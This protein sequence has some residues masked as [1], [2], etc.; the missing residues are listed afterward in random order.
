MTSPTHSLDPQVPMWLRVFSWF[1]VLWAFVLIWWG[2]AVTT[3]DVGLAVPDWPFSFGKVNPEGWWNI[4]ALKLEHG[5]RLVASGLGVVVVFLF[6]FHW[7]RAEPKWR[8]I[9]ELFGLLAVLAVNVYGVQKLT[10]L[11]ARSKGLKEQEMFDLAAQLDGSATK[12]WVLVTVTWVMVLAWLWRSWRYRGWSRLVKLGALALILVVVQAELGGLRV[13]MMSD[14]YGVMHGV[15][16]QGFFCLLLVM[17]MLAEP[18]SLLVRDSAVRKLRVVSGLLV[19][20][21]L[22]QLVVGATIR[23]TQRQ[24]L[25]ATDILTTGGAFLPDWSNTQ[26]VVIFLHKMGAI[27]AF[28]AAVVLASTAVKSMVHGMRGLSTHAG[29]L[30]VLFCAQ[31][32]LGV[33]VLYFHTHPKFEFWITQFH[34]VNGLLI[35]AMSVSVTVRS[36]RAYGSTGELA[37]R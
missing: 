1:A 25:E 12:W 5:H 7:W 10:A 17:A 9:G 30:V 18:T 34:V 33:S 32:G 8:M 20:L 14:G 11:L 37:N 31:I 27:A 4:P 23:H 21:V 26:L 2:A 3:T 19:V 22:L 35:L 13:V 16:G 6:A 29:W 24:M 28:I 15:L 36:W